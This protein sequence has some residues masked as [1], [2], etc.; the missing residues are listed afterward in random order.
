MKQTTKKNTTH[1]ATQT[2]ASPEPAKSVRRRS[3]YVEGYQFSF[4]EL[5]ESSA[6]MIALLDME[7]RYIYVTPIFL[8]VVWPET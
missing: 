7:D 4:R 2:T 6:D 3:A 1:N 8:Y 5:L